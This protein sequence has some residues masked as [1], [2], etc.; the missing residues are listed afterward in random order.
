MQAFT[1]FCRMLLDN[2]KLV[3]PLFLMVWVLFGTFLDYMMEAATGI[4]PVY[5]A[6][7]AAA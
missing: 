4:E 2:N 3:K 7:Q 1:A 6:L 5:T